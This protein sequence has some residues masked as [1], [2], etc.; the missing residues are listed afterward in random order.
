MRNYDD[1][2]PPEPPMDEPG[3]RHPG[4]VG[5]SIIPGGQNGSDLSE[6]AVRRDGFDETSIET[7]PESAATA[8]AAQATAAVNAR[9]I[10]AL[11]KPRSMDDVRVRLLKE[12]RRPGF[13]RSARYRKPIGRGV[14]GPSIRF[15][16]AAL[17]LLGNVYPETMTVYDDAEKRIVRQSVTDLETNIT[18]SKDVVIEKT[19]ERRQLKEGQS[20]IRSRLNSQGAVTY[21]VPATEDDL[22]NKENALVS[23]ALRTN[24]LRLLPGDI[25]D[26]CMAA[27]IAT[28]RDGAAKDP[29]GER[30]RVADAFAAQGVNPSDIAAY[31]GHDLG[32]TSPA[33]LVDLRAVYEAIKNGEATWKAV[34]EARESGED[35]GAPKARAASVSERLKA[36]ASKQADPATAAK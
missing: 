1:S 29:D 23:K 31:L 28:A 13:A 7:R 15:A 20:F 21:L 14:E 30:K 16:E 18:Y 8:V 9:Y 36:A 17:R 33:E 2:T 10:M 32:T 11:K 22:L 27:C 26:E 3:D 19:V 5:S 12:C 4:P 6:P 24:A 25:L 34:I 35:D